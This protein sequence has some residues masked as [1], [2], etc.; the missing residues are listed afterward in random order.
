MND[1]NGDVFLEVKVSPLSERFSVEGFN[2]WT[3]RLHVRVSEPATDGK[4]NRELVERMSDLLDRDVLVKSG[5]GSR[6]K[7]LIVK[8][9]TSKR[10]K[11]VLP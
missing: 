11:K 2:R 6:R 4:A 9:T 8:N 7:T 10:L 1:T 3:G 5:H